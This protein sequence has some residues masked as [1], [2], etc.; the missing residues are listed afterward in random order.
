M[1]TLKYNV[2]S[3]MG[4]V[5]GN[6][7][8]MALADGRLIRDDI[9]EGELHT[10]EHT[11]AV[12]AV[13][14]GMGGYEGGEVASELALRSLSTFVRD[15]PAGLDD[16]ALTVAL[17]N[18]ASGINELVLKTSAGVP[19]L[20]E[21]GTT[22]VAIF[23]YEGR[24]VFMNI[25]DSRLYRMRGG[26]LKQLSTDHSERERTGDP[27]VPSNLI[28]NYLGND[29]CFFADISMPGGQVYEG[30]IFLLCSDGLSD[31]ID[32]DT[33][34][35]TLPSGAEALVHAAKQAGGIDNITVLTVAVG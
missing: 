14:D 25:G 30:D 7:E 27:S 9:A 4:L 17:K 26:V 12:F 22:L 33:I 35:E 10:D 15:M 5:R 23:I 29:G 1:T 19:R 2:A 3:D 32:D 11:H 21:M 20:A 8:D 31:M 6:N 24:L 13:A 16:D 34:A 28:Y 18:C